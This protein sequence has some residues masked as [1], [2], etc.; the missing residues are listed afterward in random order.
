MVP[1]SLPL[2]VMT[3]LPSSSSSTLNSPV[4]TA[5]PRR[6]MRQRIFSNDT[7]SFAASR[8]MTSL[9]D[10]LQRVGGGG[11]SVRGDNRTTAD[12]R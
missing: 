1:A 8:A 11:S 4:I 7:P 6:N 10:M 3:S 2:D 12:K 9:G 5:S